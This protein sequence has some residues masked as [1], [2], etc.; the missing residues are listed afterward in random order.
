MKNKKVLFISPN[1]HVY[2]K[3]IIVELKKMGFLVD[4]FSDRPKNYSIY[5]K[6]GSY[7][8]KYSWYQHRK[9]IAK[10]INDNDYD[11][12]FV[13][14][15][16][17]IDYELALILKSI[18]NN[19]VK[20]LYQW[21]SI[22]NFDYRSILFAFDKSYTFDFEDAFNLNIYQENLFYIEKGTN[23]KKCR[24]IDILFVG[25]MHGER[26]KQLALIQQKNRDFKY[27]IHLYIPFLT[28]LKLKFKGEN[29]R[30]RDVS[31][32]KISYKKMLRLYRRSK[33]VVDFQS[34]LQTG[35]TI[36]TFESLGNGCKLIT[37][38]N[39]IKNSKIYDNNIIHILSEDGVVINKMF[40]DINSEKELISDYY[41]ID[42]WL[43][44][45]IKV[46][47]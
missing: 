26:N 16:E 5:N 47:C 8:K 27:K 39:Y 34:N 31:F 15:G 35:L 13:I 43:K 12:I 1:F 28:F 30:Y 21:D 44:R 36:R 3:E 41:R 2:A 42:N 45:I 33:V 37:S 40:V 6:L 29:I 38:N 20:I 23:K 11:V 19:C 17:T 32:I 10:K 4:C 9:K 24:D 46:D 22:N 18:K 25:G 7:I 14:K